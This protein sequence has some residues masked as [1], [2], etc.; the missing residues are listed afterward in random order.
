MSFE[1]K[2]ISCWTKTWCHVLVYAVSVGLN[3]IT[4]KYG[5]D[6][7]RGVSEFCYRM[8]SILS[9]LYSLLV[10]VTI[11]IPLVRL[12]FIRWWTEKVKSRGT[13][14]HN[15]SL[16]QWQCCQLGFEYMYFVVNYSSDNLLELSRLFLW[17]TI[18][19]LFKMLNG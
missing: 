4:M 11:L 1:P 14:S 15:M 19:M 10:T 18:T 2:L 5:M 6:L 16:R 3:G 17:G 13:L 9:V 12:Y 8:E 7:E